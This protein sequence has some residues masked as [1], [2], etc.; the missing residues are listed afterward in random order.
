MRANHRGVNVRPGVDIDRRD[1]QAVSQVSPTGA[2]VPP[3]IHQVAI[4]FDDRV[5]RAGV[6]PGLD[7]FR[8]HL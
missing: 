4:G 7:L 8:A 1:D 3:V 2:V 6:Q 5:S